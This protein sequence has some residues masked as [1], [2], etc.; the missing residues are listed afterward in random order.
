MKLKLQ[1]TNSPKWREV[2]SKKPV[3]SR[4]GGF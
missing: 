3:D 1:M 4:E 2:R